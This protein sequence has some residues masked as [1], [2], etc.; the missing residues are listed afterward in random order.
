MLSTDTGSL[1][2]FAQ[3]LVDEG[4]LSHEQALD[5]AKMADQ[6]QKPLILYLSDA[7]ILPSQQ[8]A[9]LASK[10]YGLPLYDLVAHDK[11]LIPQ[12][13]LELNIVLSKQGMPIIKNHDKLVIAVADPDSANLREISFIT[14]LKTEFIIVEPNALKKKIDELTSPLETIEEI[15]FDSDLEINAY[16]DSQDNVVSYDIDDTPVVRFVNKILIDAIRSKSSDIHFE[17][18]EKMYRVR[19]RQDGILFEVANPPIKLANS[20]VARL[21]V[22]ANLDISERR[23]P[24]DGRFK[25]TLGHGRSIDFRMSTLPTMNGEKVVL[26]ILDPTGSELDLSS[27]GFEDKQKQDYLKA[28]N[29]SQGIILVTGPTGSGKTVTLYSALRILNRIEKNIS[30]IEDPVEIYMQ[31]VNQV[32]VNEKTGMTFA[33][34]L[35]AFLRQDPDIMMVGEIRDLET[36]EISIKAAQT[37]HLVLSTLH[38]NSAPETLDRLR[39]I[40]IQAFNIASSVIL[41]MAQRLVRK[42]CPLCKKPEN[43]TPEIIKAAGFDPEIIGNATIY[44]PGGCDQCNNGY[45]SR[46]GVFEVLPIT[47]ETQNLIM[48]GGTTIDLRVQMKKEGIKSLTVSAMEKVRDG[49]TSF[50]EINRVISR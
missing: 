40:G 9:A 49:L 16:D 18:Y 36:A 33:R 22:M 25:L 19:Y 10:T 45:K 12:E 32:Q 5:A 26:R 28:I 34:A 46:L 20:L 2:I 41:V 44:G 15:D 48:Q 7:K 13:F 37:G 24:Q 47:E 11:N 39:N 30:T 3:R 43:I 31:G 35:R 6:E 1:N 17:P 8:L 4:L 29:L 38:T 42:L 23:V 14:G 50:E 27:L 21:K